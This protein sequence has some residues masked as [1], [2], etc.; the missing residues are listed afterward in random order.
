MMHITARQRK[1]FCSE[2]IE[3]EAAKTPNFLELEGLFGDSGENPVLLVLDCLQNLLLGF[4][5]ALGPLEEES[6]GALG[7]GSGWLDGGDHFEI[8]LL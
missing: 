2:F 1:A 4:S 8:V 5:D 3:A 6:G 7:E